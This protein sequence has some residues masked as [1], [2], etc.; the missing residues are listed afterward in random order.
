MIVGCRPPPFIPD[1]REPA[2]LQKLSL[3]DLRLLL[4]REPW[5]V[6]VKLVANARERQVGALKR[7]LAAWF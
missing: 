3:L 4:R 6:M 5:D 2:D 7:K 1:G